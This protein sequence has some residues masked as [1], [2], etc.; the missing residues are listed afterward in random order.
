MNPSKSA[1]F[2]GKAE[3]RWNLLSRIGSGDGGLASLTLK[4]AVEPTQRHSAAKPQPRP[5]WA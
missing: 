5:N 1:T 3:A 2:S 4:R